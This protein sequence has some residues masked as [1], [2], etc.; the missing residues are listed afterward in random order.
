V[1][2]A[3][4]SSLRVR[5]L[6]FVFDDDIPFQ[7]NPG[8]P[9]FGNA[10][11]FM[12]VIGP[13]FERYF[14]R[15]TR[16]AM[17]LLRDPQARKN[18]QD[19]CG[20]EAAHA[21]QHREHVAMLA[22]KYPGLADG[23]ARVD[24]SYDRLFEERDLEFHLSYMVF[25]EDNFSPFACF[26]MEHLDKLFVDSDPR[27]A[28]FLLWHFVEEFEHRSSAARI[29]HHVV[30]SPWPRLRHVPAVVAHIREVG[31]TTMDAFREHIPTADNLCAHDD[32]RGAM[33]GIPWTARLR[34]VASLVRSQ[35]PGYD[36]EALPEPA[37]MAG[38]H[39]AEARGDDMTRHPLE[40]LPRARA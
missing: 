39:A 22:R 36:A 4:P 32:L 31:E 38:W 27:I 21:R 13:A 30:G 6:A 37:W 1:E 29:Y 11:N 35:L 20:Q 23:M 17:P 26:A 24:A 16:Q 10:M 19:F 25:L 15:A 2:Q 7:W 33:R 18:A 9:G 28:R 8:N 3:P 34:L 40:W 5:K 14:I 12:T